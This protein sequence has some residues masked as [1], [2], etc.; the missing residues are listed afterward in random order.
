M[1]LSGQF[2]FASD[3]LL[4]IQTMLSS[5][6]TLLVLFLCKDNTRLHLSAS[7]WVFIFY[8]S[9]T[10]DINRKFVILIGKKRNISSGCSVFASLKSI[11][12]IWK[13]LI[14]T[15]DLQQLRFSELHLKVAT[16]GSP[17]RWKN[18]I[19][20]DFFLIENLFFQCA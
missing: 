5:P 18:I 9:P 12:L 1:L 2:S 20:E 11:S 4:S 10:I 6:F 14:K 19:A 3:S 7:L 17:K 8:T 16:R 13:H 15:F